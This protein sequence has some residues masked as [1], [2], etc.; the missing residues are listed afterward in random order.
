MF[1]RSRVIGDVARK[2]INSTTSEFALSRHAASSESAFT[3][4][5]VG[6]I[7]PWC[8]ARKTAIEANSRELWLHAVLS[9]SVNL[10]RRLLD[11]QTSEGERWH[12][13][14]SD[15]YIHSYTHSTHIPHTH[16]H[17]QARGARVH[18]HTSACARRGPL[19]LKPIVHFN[20]DLPEF[21][22]AVS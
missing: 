5:C 16:V 14:R 19:G 3:R 7:R 21:A 22:P 6:A 2:P 1:C 9:E 4:D 8:I 10:G 13:Q 20:V 18:E 17:A 11:G 12:D 15:T